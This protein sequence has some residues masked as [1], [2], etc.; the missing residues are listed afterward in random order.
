VSSAGPGRLLV[1]AETAAAL[2]AEASAVWGL[3][4]F[5]LV[6]TAGRSCAD[7][8]IRSGVFQ[9]GTRLRGEGFAAAVKELN[10]GSIV[11]ESKTPW[12]SAQGLLGAARTRGENKRRFFRTG[13]D[14]Q[15][16]VAL[17]GPG[18]NGADALVM[19]RALVMRGVACAQNSAA[20]LSRDIRQGE[21]NPRTAAVTALRAMG[22]PVE[23]WNSPTS[24]NLLRRAGIILDGIAGTGLSGALRGVLLDMALAINALRGQTAPLVAA[25]DLP[26]GCCGAW[27]PGSPVVRADLTL[28]VE[29]VK[30]SLFTPD[31]RP[32][33]GTILP[34]DR[35]FPAPLMERYGEGKSASCFPALGS[36][37]LL[38]WDE[39]ASLVP[40]V[41]P[42]AY[43]YSRGVAELH[44]GARG[45]S[46]AARLAA[47][48]AQAAG[49]GLVRLIVDDELYPALAG[50]CGGIMTAPRSTYAESR[51]N[52]GAI[53]AGPGWGRDHSRFSVLARLLEAE[54]RGVPLILDAD[55]I[56]LVREHFERSGAECRFHGSALLT[57]H[58]G[59]LEAFSG[60]SK[61]LLLSE[62]SL[63][64]EL[65]VRYNAVILFKS[66]VMIIASPPDGKLVYVDGMNPV[67]AAG[68]S[69]DLLAGLCA[70]LAARCTACGREDGKNGC[71]TG[72]LAGIAS[73]AASLLA[74][75]ARRV[76]GFCD[77]LELAGRAAL[78]AGGAWLP[79]RTVP[80]AGK[81]AF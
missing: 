15:T 34:V 55:G 77:P 36:S 33:C 2:D 9:S 67:L 16:V 65:A 71:G 40:A 68:G 45:F 22:I 30:R 75:S 12:G 19:L 48:G 25:I 41:P 72:E 54:A 63:L 37:R 78:L 76:R 57:P 64:S 28:A 5:A 61:K 80:R 29:P 6:E 7:V 38:S 66:H 46:G 49:A 14:A 32:F 79:R 35:I 13:E 20:L 39:A 43:K 53:L 52:P 24:E 47:S 62:P 3:N 42:D 26:S 58:A 44:A 17:A 31:L 60:V 11:Y 23:V 69:G 59:E 70:G 4:P 27:V 21:N 51:F 74:A 10:T 18:N 8:F 56:A 50:H 1:S 73:A 81:R